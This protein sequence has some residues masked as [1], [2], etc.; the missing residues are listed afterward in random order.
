MLNNKISKYVQSI[1]PS[2]IRRFFDL[3]SQLDDVISLGV[4]EPDFITPWNICEAAIYNIEKG[5]T[6]YTS[7]KG[8]IRLR[9]EIS[10]YLKKK[11]KL[12]YDPE[13]EIIVTVGASQAIDI[14][15]RAII[16]PG[17]EIII[18][19]PSYV[20]YVP[21]VILCGG[22]PVIFQTYMEDNFR[23]RFEDLK[24]K[25]TKRT[26]GI[27]INYPSNPTGMTLSKSDLEQLR[28][29]AI[30]YDLVVIAD[31]IYAEILFEGNHISIA[32]LPNMK[33]RTIL[34]SGFS[35]AFA[36]TGWRIGYIAADKVLIDAVTK[37]HQY[38]ILCAPIISQL[39]AIE[40]LT[41]SSD[42][43]EKMVDSYQQRRNVMID[44]FNQIGLKCSVPQG[45]FY[46][47]PSIKRLGLSSEGF[48][49]RL[50]KKEKVVVI[51][52]NIFGECGEGHIRC[53]F[54]TYLNDIEE[55]IIR[56]ERF[57]NNLK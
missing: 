25:I 28:R 54:A 2:G 13:N 50:L 22:N 44:G 36:M 32:N 1:S 45:A 57:I 8:L 5:K 55:S 51:P 9:Q 21:M 18:P 42:E 20:S 10:R 56:I 27:L 49:E 4:G 37:I 23:I 7:N 35:K 52:G 14:A 16:N 26:K 40:A 30:D 38:S 53:S 47:F 31:E 41:D 39:A 19:Q 46:A 6:T 17:D 3:A 48:T 12:E 15:L 34:I 43:I 33:E 24:N 29:I 11:F